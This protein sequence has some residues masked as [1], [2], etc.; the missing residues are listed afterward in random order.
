MIRGNG[1]GSGELVRAPRWMDWP[2][3]MAYMREH[4]RVGE[5]F[6]L[7]STTESGKTTFAVRLLDVRDFVVV[8]GT[9][10]RDPSLYGPLES[11]G[12]VR[13]DDW[14]PYDWRETNERRVIYAPPLKVEPNMTDKQL[15]E[16]EAEQAQAFR[17]VLI[18]IYEAGAWTIYIDEMGHLADLGLERELA[19]NYREG[20]S[21]NVTMVAGTQRPRNVPLVMFMLANWQATWRISDRQDRARAAEFVGEL[22]PMLDTYARRIGRFEALVIHK[23]TDWAARTKVEI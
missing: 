17:R 16:A 4:W 13:R 7:V 21:E 5:H 12:Y 8:L 10:K 22:G 6:S 9:K 19:R 20:R 14:T 1:R 2:D 15:R 18:E 3:F 23:P 11:R